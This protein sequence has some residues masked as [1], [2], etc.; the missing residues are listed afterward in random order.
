MRKGLA[1]IGIYK[2]VVILIIVFW[3]NLFSQWANDPE[4]NTLL[5]TDTNDPINISAVKDLNGGAMLF[6]Q[7]K[8]DK[9]NNDIY[10]IHINK[11]GGT[12]S[13]SDGKPV[14]LTN[15]AKENPM[16]VLDSGGD[17]IVIWKEIN[18]KNN[19]GLYVQKLTQSGLRLWNANGINITNLPNEESD[20]NIETDKNKDVYI[21]YIAKTN[22][23]GK[24]NSVRY[25]KL[26]LSGFALTDSSKRIIYSSDKKLSQTNIIPDNKGGAYIFWLENIDSKINIRAQYVD[27]TGIKKWGSNPLGV[28]KEKTNVISYSLGKVGPYIYAA[29]TY[30]G[31]EKTIYQQLISADGKLLWGR[32]GKVLTNQSGSQT[33]PNF[34]FTDSSIVVCW[35]NQFKKIKDIYA[36][37]FDI[38]GQRLWGNNDLRVINLKGNQFGQR[39]ISDKKGNLIIAWLNKEENVA[40]VDLNIQKI[41]LNGKLLWD[42]DGVKISSSRS[43]RKSYLNLVSD[44]DGGA[45]AIFK[46][47]VEGKNNIY[48]QKIFST[49]TYASQILG[50]DANVVNDSVKIFWYSANEN[51]GTE[52]IVQR[53]SIEQEGSETNW[54]SIDTLIMSCKNYVNYYEYAEIPEF[55]GSI[56]YRIMQ[57]NNGS[58]PY[59]TSPLKVDYFINSEKIVLAQNSPNPFSSSTTINFYLPQDEN[60]SIEIFNS[61]IEMIQKVEK[62][63]FPAG[64]NSYVFNANGLEPGIY[65]YR[66]KVDDFVDVKKMILTQ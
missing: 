4:A 12:G 36:Q 54:E 23:A 37:R 45:I 62:Q 38:N 58:Q 40:T 59:T 48:G 41:D 26:N 7:D 21:S 18:G 2:L 53:A 42:Q 34:V 44:E 13:R 57:V 55:S 66:L 30:Q 1:N 19:P 6:W 63:K 28:S 25:V 31:K 8:K 9:G 65:F 20:Y 46:G 24:K 56:Y 3:S 29:I 64:K 51:Q 49:G 43:M 50:F 10:F 11:D 15:S 16:A 33:N 17:A 27:S 32:D 61:N 22:Q 39:M 35:T 52:Y 60:V 14:S 5:V 47:T